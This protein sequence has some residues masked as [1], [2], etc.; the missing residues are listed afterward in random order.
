MS[1]KD[2]E[3][4]LSNFEPSSREA[5]MK[6]LNNQWKPPESDYLRSLNSSFNSWLFG[7]FTFQESEQV[8]LLAQEYCEKTEAY[9]RTVCTGPMGVD[10]ILPNN[11]REYLL[12]NRFAIKLAR[13]IYKRSV[14]LGIP[15]EELRKAISNYRLNVLQGARSAG[16][17]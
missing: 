15:H 13:E 8:Y 6:L 16:K 1:W 10:G 12:I 9:D 11:P 17:G 4:D 2:V 7:E 3:L 5:W 14:E